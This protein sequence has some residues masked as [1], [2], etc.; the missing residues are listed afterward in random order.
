MG[1]AQSQW[2][3]QVWPWP[4]PQC[5]SWEQ[6]LLSRSLTARD[7][8]SAGGPQTTDN[9]P[10]IKAC[11]FLSQAQL[12]DS[13]TPQNTKERRA[14]GGKHHYERTSQIPFKVQKPRAAALLLV[15]L[16]TSHHHSQ[17]TCMRLNKC[18]LPSI[19]QPSKLGYSLFFPVL[20]PIPAEEFQVSVHPEKV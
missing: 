14:P 2:T 4:P 11:P 17:E 1:M 10:I 8:P 20:C 6:I 15:L 13:K 19:P 18:I 5:L 16:L 9:S 7:R 3:P 12:R